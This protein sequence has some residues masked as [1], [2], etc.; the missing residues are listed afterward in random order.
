MLEAGSNC[1]REGGIRSRA[2][3]IYICSVF[4]RQNI[5]HRL[6]LGNRILAL[7]EFLNPDLS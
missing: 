7:V 5:N 6:S 4:K 2:D 3:V 1:K